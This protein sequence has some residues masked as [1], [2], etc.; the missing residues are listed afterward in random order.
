MSA[1]PVVIVPAV[2]RSEDFSAVAPDN[3]PRQEAGQGGALV[4][5]SN[6]GPK[7]VDGR[8]SM[9]TAPLIDALTVTFRAGVLK[10]TGQKGWRELVTWLFGFA[11]Q[12][13]MGSVQKR[14]WQ[15]YDEHALLLDQ[16]GAVV[17]KVGWVTREGHE[18]QG[19]FCVS[20]MGHGTRHL[21]QSPKGRE[22]LMH[23]LLL[24][25]AKITRIDIAVDDLDGSTLN[26]WAIKARAQQGEF[27]TRGRP[28]KVWWIEHDNDGRGNTLYIGQKGH[29]ELCLYEKGKQ[30]G[31]PNSGYMR[32]ELRLYGA[33]IELPLDVLVNLGEYFGA[34]YPLLA[35]FVVSELERLAIKEHVYLDCTVNGWLRS[36]RQQ[37]GT[38]IGLAMR[39]L[40]Q[41]NFLRFA[42]D[43]QRTGVP[44]RFKHF[45]GDI[46]QELRKS[47]ER[48]NDHGDQE[49]SDR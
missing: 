12:V 31:D 8:D 26:Y 29:K 25:C 30:L 39:A 7:G 13:V 44:G 28:P 37:S 15:F 11:D 5:G 38:S 14:T 20:L 35:D 42:Q 36:L 45:N 21:E 40:G 19:A 46:A 34:A 3:K 33:R 4:P 23:R 6:T 18:R 2:Q 27:C 48:G 41:E 47:I 32:F 22:A 24:A 1:L 49:P 16:S 10:R 17:G 43:L 9:L